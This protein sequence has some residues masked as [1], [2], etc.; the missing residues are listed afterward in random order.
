MNFDLADYFKLLANHD[1]INILLRLAEKKESN[2]GDLVADS[3]TTHSAISQHLSVLR[4]GGVV[5]T[6]RVAQNIYYSLT[7]KGL[8]MAGVVMRVTGECLA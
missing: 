2:V 7:A 8:S 3:L 6:R 4:K 1:R 5:K